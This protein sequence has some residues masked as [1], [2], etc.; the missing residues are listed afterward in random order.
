MNKTSIIITTLLA[1]VTLTGQGQVKCY[2][3]GELRDTTQGKT[4]VICLANVDLRVSDNYITT[5]ADAQ[6]HFSCNVETDK[7][8]LYKVFLREQW[9]RGSWKYAN[10]LVENGANVSL[11]FDD[12]QWKVISGGPEQTLKVAM[13]AEADR[14][15]RNKM[16]AI[17]KQ[18]EAEI[19]PKV[20]ALLAQGKNPEE[21]TLLMKRNAEFMTENE[22]L[23]DEYKA[24]EMEYYA[25]HPMQYTLYDI[26]DQMQYSSS[27][28]DNLINLY[29][30]SYEKFHPENTIHNTIRTLEATWLLKPGKPYIDFEARTAEGEKV[31]VSSLYKG[32]VAI[33]DLWASW[34]GPCRQHSRDLIPLY[35]KY[36]DKGFTVVG[37]ARED[38][39]SRMTNA[40]KKDGYPWQNLVDLKDELNV[41]QK[42]GLSF[43]GGGMY[44]ID[45]DGTILSTS[46]E[47]DELE[48]LIRKALDL[49]EETTMG[50]KA[51]AELNR[52][53]AKDPT[54]PFTDFSVVYNGKTTH[55]SDYVGRGQ[56]VL[57]DFWASW[58]AP[59]RE[60]IPSIIAVY[61]KYKSKGLQVLG[62]AVTDKPAHTETAI[63]E[64]GITYPQIINSQKIATDAYGIQA[65]PYSILL[66]PDG[67]I[68]ARGL[69]GEEIDAKLKE[70][71]NDK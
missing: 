54:K 1:L 21:D 31:K 42:N 16:N 43:A 56:Y 9:E 62:I 22:K 50:W 37:I 66:A 20:E 64:L 47:V 71:F 39:V 49:P 70:I 38:E 52:I 34:C 48:P 5:E 45:R 25:A 60:E 61:N 46:T 24:W 28:Q 26:A 13:D 44:L 55:L 40:A 6:G 8:S 17:N 41:W 32:K 11:R 2:I 3:E 35:E 63:K 14:L 29:H 58:C 65:I 18:A 10:Y 69:R 51:E 27:R 7:M 67:T 57:V 19:R 15:Y 12:N 59:C 23:Y 53:E 30:S 68:L 4:V 33:I 36:K